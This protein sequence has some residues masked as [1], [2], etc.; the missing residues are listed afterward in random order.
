MASVSKYAILN[1]TRGLKSSYCVAPG[2]WAFVRYRWTNYSAL[3][4]RR[5]CSWRT[6]RPDEKRERAHA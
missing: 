6:R 5:R 4:A 2:G 3:V 1:E